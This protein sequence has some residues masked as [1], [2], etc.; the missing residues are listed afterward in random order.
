MG[1]PN[2]ALRS[3]L[4]PVHAPAIAAIWEAN[5]WTEDQFLPLSVILLSKYTNTNTFTE[6]KKR[7]L[8][9]SERLKSY[10]QIPENADLPQPSFEKGGTNASFLHS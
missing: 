10:V 1:D 2:E 6:K 7:L 9:E 5:Q 4:W 3:C 8:G